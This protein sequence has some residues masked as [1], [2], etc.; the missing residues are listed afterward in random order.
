MTA[1]I[2]KFYKLIEHFD[3]PWSSED[4]Q[5]TTTNSSY[6]T[7]DKFYF[8]EFIYIPAYNFPWFKQKLEEL[9]ETALK[10]NIQPIEFKL[11]EQIIKNDVLFYKV[12][13]SGEVSKIKGWKFVGTIEPINDGMGV[14][15]KPFIGIE[16]PE[17]YNNIKSSGW[18]DH[19]KQKK[20]NTVTYILVNNSG[21]YRRIRESCLKEFLEQDPHKYLSFAVMLSELI[22]DAK[23]K[24]NSDNEHDS[25]DMF[26]AYT[27]SVVKKCGYSFENTAKKVLQAR[28]S[29]IH[30]TE[31]DYAIAKDAVEY[32]KD[33]LE[34][35]PML[36]G[37]ENDM[38][39]C[40][41]NDVVYLKD[42]AQSATLIIGY[43]LKRKKQEHSPV[44]TKAANPE[45]E[46]VGN[47]GERMHFKKVKLLKVQTEETD[48]GT[49]Y[50]NIMM[51]ADNNVIIWVGTKNAEEAGMEL[52]KEYQFRGKVKAHR[53]YKNKNTGK[54]V[55]TTC[56][57]V[58]KDVTEAFDM[59]AIF[60]QANDELGAE[61]AKKT[62][63][64]L[65][66]GKRQDF[67]VTVHKISR[68]KG[69]NGEFFKHLLKDG[70]GRTIMWNASKQ[71]GMQVG[72][73]Y[74]LMANPKKEIDAKFKGNP[75]K[76]LI[77]GNV[78]FKSIGRQS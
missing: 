43:Y 59:R 23:E 75:E 13:I 29:G 67:V 44:I 28:S 18:C 6:D 8:D 41:K 34:S 36:K 58:V 55:K 9:N 46:F 72:K 12:T 68:E 61:N 32:V 65:E 22:N 64:Q 16:V 33:K 40:L 21:E 3:N 11:D 38:L 71:S 26:L 4:T 27:V 35:K 30:P 66:K 10:F 48:F 74:S 39:E 50:Y 45:S 19:C 53:L 51:D 15:I 49:K 76:V 31:Q 1:D 24:K 14:V 42:H 52:D 69:Q 70:S 56:I 62:G 2:I 7:T 73:R 57:N 54:L 5:E 77:I 25:I 47:P 20:F 78:D 60:N 17:Q 37:F 63:E